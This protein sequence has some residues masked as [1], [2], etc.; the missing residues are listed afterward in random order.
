[1]LKAK[2]PNQHGPAF[3]NKS[4]SGTVRLVRTLFYDAG[5]VFFLAPMVKAFFTEVWR[6]PNR[7]RKVVLADISTLEHLAGCKALGLVNKFVT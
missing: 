7:L 1:M 5:V 2:E 3:V 4:E 6:T